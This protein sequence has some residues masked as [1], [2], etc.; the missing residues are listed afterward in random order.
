MGTEIQN[1]QKEIVEWADSISAKRTP[2]NTVVKLVS[3]TSEL[4]DVIVND[5]YDV[6]GEL[7]DCT[8][9][10]LDLADMYGVD[11]LMAVREKMGIN[12]DRKWENVNGV[13]RRKKEY[14]P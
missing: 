12:R 10:L 9:L 7:A 14:G 13:I 1:L 5:D 3:E 2:V 6:G 4:L 8:I 11:L